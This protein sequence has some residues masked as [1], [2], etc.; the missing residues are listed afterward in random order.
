ML[1]SAALFLAFV[2]PLCVLT[3][4]LFAARGLHHLVLVLVAAPALALAWPHRLPFARVGGFVGLSV[5]LWLW[6]LPAAYT[7][8]WNSHAIYW[9]M[10]AG[11][12]GPGWAFWSQVFHAERPA[13]RIASVGMVLALA[14]QMGLIA[15]ILTFSPRVL[16]VQHLGATQA[17]GL[18]ALADQQ[19]AGLVMW[20][21]GM[22]PL[23]FLGALLLR[24]GW[25]EASLT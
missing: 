12:L 10:Q 24:R 22:L 14:G 8:A 6:H 3:V 9:T 20:V 17:Y 4:G 13:E 7:L 25:R 21:P 23:A 2:S 18:D 1:A 16:Y 15:A 19:L 5:F 11:M